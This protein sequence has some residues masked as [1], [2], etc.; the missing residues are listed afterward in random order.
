MDNRIAE[1][2]NKL[3]S[4]INAVEANPDLSDQKKKDEILRLRR[5]SASHKTII[6]RKFGQTVNRRTSTPNAS[7]Q[8][9]GQT[10]GQELPF[11]ALAEKRKRKSGSSTDHKAKKQQIEVHDAME[12][13]DLSHPERLVVTDTPQ[14]LSSAAAEESSAVDPASTVH[15][16]QAPKT[17]RKKILTTRGG[18]YLSLWDKQQPTDSVSA[19]ASTIA[20]TT[21]TG[22]A[23]EHGKLDKGKEKELLREASEGYIPVGAD[24][25][26]ATPSQAVGTPATGQRSSGL[27][28]QSAA[29]SPDK[30]AARRNIISLDSDEEINKP[31]ANREIEEEEDSDGDYY[32][33]PPAPSMHDPPSAATMR[34]SHAL[35]RPTTSSS[36]T[37]VAG[38][39][40][41]TR[42]APAHR[43]GQATTTS[44]VPPSQRRQKPKEIK[45]TPA[46]PLII[47][48]VSIGLAATGAT[49]HATPPSSCRPVK[50]SGPGGQPAASQGSPTSPVAPGKRPGAKNVPGGPGMG[51][52]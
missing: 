42:V 38:S 1:E 11:Q 32:V 44:R 20:T 8:T 46:R 50:R 6:R 27:F 10:S 23:S 15:G 37:R 22:N 36:S 29:T 31:V 34:A 19:S 16:K 12:L 41:S 24:T 9:S 49:R 52:L 40:S 7:G 21:A 13:D 2:G 48:G 43:H 14:M 17:K 33:R 18:G 5:N 45:D 30:P 4:L 47:G 26:F 28:I 25:M 35:D 39:S 51:L 3:Q